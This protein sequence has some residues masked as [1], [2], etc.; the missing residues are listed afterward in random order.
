MEDIYLIDKLLIF[1]LGRQES[2]VYVCLLKHGALT[3]YEVSKITGISRSNVYNSLAAL[4]EHGA[5]YVMEG[6]SSKYVAVPMAEFCDNHIRY[7]S[8]LKEILVL[9]SPRE[10]VTDEGYLTIEG[11]THIR[12]KIHHM[13]TGA[14]QRIYFSASAEFLQAWQEEI[15]GLL[16]RNSKV[17]L[18]SD[19]HPEFS[20]LTDEEKSNII[21]YE[22]LPQETEESALWNQQEQVQLIVD[23][24][25]VLTG[26]YRGQADDTCLYSAQRN[27]VNAIK[28]GMRN[29]IKLIELMKKQ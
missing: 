8:M 2:A 28:A 18:L 26:T 14:K 23:S 13:L 7:L 9:N 3:G 15:A 29:E 11:S 5:A 16:R 6:S 25:Y 24:E 20:A 22:H 27:F 21:Y 1:G 12:N 17:V 10:Q 19:R 4:V